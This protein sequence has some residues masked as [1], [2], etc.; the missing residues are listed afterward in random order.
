MG[1]GVHLLAYKM[2]IGYGGVFFFW[3]NDIDRLHAH[4]PTRSPAHPPEWA[5]RGP[6]LIFWLIWGSCA[7][8]SRVMFRVGVG[9][10]VWVRGW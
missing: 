4:V 1:E 8:R 9:L 6:A 5:E 3:T 10:L 2:K 7:F